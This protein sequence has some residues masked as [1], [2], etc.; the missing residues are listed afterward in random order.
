M[1]KV[2]SFT[3]RVGSTTNS[4]CGTSVEIKKRKRGGLELR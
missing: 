4:F 2:E 1:E 3:V